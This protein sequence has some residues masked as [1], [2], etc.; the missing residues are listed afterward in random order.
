MVSFSARHDIP[1]LGEL[2]DSPIYPS[3]IVD[4]VDPEHQKVPFSILQLVL[5]VGF[6]IGSGMAPA[7]LVPEFSTVDLCATRACVNVSTSLTKD[8]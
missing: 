6:K 8:I 1:T 4:V 3:C 2:F 7:H 5:P